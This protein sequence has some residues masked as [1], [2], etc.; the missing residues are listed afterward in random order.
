MMMEAVCSSETLL[1]GHMTTR[2]SNQEDHHLFSPHHENLNSYMNKTC[3]PIQRRTTIFYY[4][5]QENLGEDV[6]W[7][8]KTHRQVENPCLTKSTRTPMKEKL[9]QTG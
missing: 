5:E 2:C 1:Y 6:S 4:T 9:W 3:F 7:S 8:H